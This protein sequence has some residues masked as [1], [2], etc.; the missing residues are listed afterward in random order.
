MSKFFLRHSLSFFVAFLLTAGIAVARAQ[1]PPVA[2]EPDKER[3]DASSASLSLMFDA[4]GNV[5][6]DFDAGIG[7]EQFRRTVQELSKALH[8]EVQVVDQRDWEWFTG[9]CH[10]GFQRNFLIV[11]GEVDLG[12]LV[13]FLKTLGIRQMFLEIEHPLTG[14]TEFSPGGELEPSPDTAIVSYHIPFDLP[15][16]SAIHFSYGYRWRDLWRASFPLVVILLLPLGLTLRAR[17][18]ALAAHKDEHPAAWFGFSRFLQWTGLGTLLVWWTA[19]DALQVHAFKDFM[20]AGMDS[21]GQLANSFSS[22]LLLILFPPLM[23]NIACTVLSYP[24][25]SRIRGVRWTRRE[26]FLQALWGQAS[27]FLPFLFFLTGLFSFFSEEPRTGVLWIAAAYV[28]LVVGR[29]R[30]ASVMDWTPHALT[31]GEL[32]D[33]LFALAAKAKIKLQQIYVLPAGKGNMTNAFAAQGNS[34]LLTDSLLRNLNKRE[35]DAVMAHELAHL[36]HRHPAALGAI[37][38]LGITGALVLDPFLHESHLVPPWLPLMPLMVLLSLL[39]FYL[40][41]RRYESAADAGA[42]MLSGDAEALITGLVKVY[43]LNM[44]PLHWGKWQEKTLTHPSSVRRAQS[45]A[46]LAG[47]P[48]EQVP[49]I[50]ATTEAEGEHYPI[51]HAVSGEGKVFSS[52]RKGR[53]SLGVAWICIAAMTIPPAVIA[54]LVR[55]CGWQGP[56]RWAAYLGGVIVTFA[57]SL[58]ASNFAAF[59][60]YAGLQRQLRARLEQR[61]IPCS[62]LG[63]RFVGLSPGSAPRLYEKH[64]IWDIGFLFIEGNRLCYVGEETQFALRTDQIADLSIGANPPG[65]WRTENICVSWRD[66]EG[67][68]SQSFLLRPLEVR[69]LGQLGREVRVLGERLLAWW[70]SPQAAPQACE[71]LAE[72]MPPSL[73]EISSLRP[74]EVI[75]REK[76]LIGLFFMAIVASGVALLLGLPFDWDGVTRWVWELF[77]PVADPSPA[78][79]GFWYVVGVVLFVSFLQYVPFFRYR[80]PTA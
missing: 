11:A 39:I 74:R 8:C 54:L 64:W 25:Q 61:G 4:Q 38:A 30:L 26:M 6:I 13:G 46:R 73:G 51:P 32:R 47:I 1:K 78:D 63:G 69:S 57:L 71:S 55:L 36:K 37:F 35:V 41:S 53:I 67:G 77:A 28:T 45:I 44:L 9:R 19:V 58:L 12:S 79:L 43:R 75:K 24:V 56:A 49:S 27:S 16:V 20:L 59:L 48:A 2:Q 42:V 60:G 65:W 31:V 17:R 18:V 80:E 52:L 29:Q 5:E 72:L 62:A 3:V 68:M 21:S 76:I 66:A 34:V 7:P 14:F 10:E 22:S 40:F 23:I 15:S 33:R 70:R 50:L